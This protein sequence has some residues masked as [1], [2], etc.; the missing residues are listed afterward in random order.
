MMIILMISEIVDNTFDERYTQI[1]FFLFLM[2]SSAKVLLL[3]YYFI[4]FRVY[5]LLLYVQ[6]RSLLRLTVTI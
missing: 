6:R 1:L 5:I 4:H 3:L 2:T